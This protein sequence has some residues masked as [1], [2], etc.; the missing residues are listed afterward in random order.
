MAGPF[1]FQPEILRHS[2]FIQ[3]VESVGFESLDEAFKKVN[4]CIGRPVFVKTS[5]SFV[6]ES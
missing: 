5:L 2:Q 1:S 3:I 4:V 6:Q